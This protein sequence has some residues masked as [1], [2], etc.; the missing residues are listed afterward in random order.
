MKNVILA[1]LAAVVAL[2]GCTTTAPKQPASQIQ[3]QDLFDGKRIPNLDIAA[4]GAL[5]AFADSG[6]LLRRSEDNGKTWGPIIQLPGDGNGSC[7]VDTNTG[8]VLLVRSGKAELC[9]SKDNGK[10][11]QIE[12][13]TIHPNPY[14]TARPTVFRWTPVAPSPASP[15]PTAPTRDAS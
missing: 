14:A 12:P 13:I 1:C 7:I 10:T 4:D 8:D 5:L 3:V 6:R 9:R 11:W 15:W 2:T